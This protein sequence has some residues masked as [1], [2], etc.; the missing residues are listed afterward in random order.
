V[1][2]V[3]LGLV[4]I[5]LGIALRWS[6]VRNTWFRAIHLIAITI[7]VVESA[8]GIPCP[9]TVWEHRLR[10]LAGQAGHQG[11]FI[12]YW[13]HRLIF[14]RAEPWVF[15]L[16]YTLFGVAVLAAFVLAPP[17]WS[18]R[19]RRGTTPGSFAN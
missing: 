13:T 3:V 1:S 18:G 16:V 8:A 7:V 12:A 19:S 10:Q 9:L 2:F 15:T 14:Y 5:L 6:W 4:L 17:G 11:D